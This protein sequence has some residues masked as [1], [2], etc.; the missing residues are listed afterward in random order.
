MHICALDFQILI[1]MY[2][3]FIT[4]YCR[5]IPLRSMEDYKNGM[6]VIV[7]VLMDGGMD[8]WLGGWMDGWMDK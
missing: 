7:V 2:S 6:W 8:G 1:L 4:C 5:E 3:V